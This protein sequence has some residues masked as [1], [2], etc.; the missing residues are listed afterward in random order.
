M[1]SWHCVWLLCTHEEGLLACAPGSRE[2]SDH[3]SPLSWE[4]SRYFILSP[5]VISCLQARMR[6][7]VCFQSDLP[8]SPEKVFLNGV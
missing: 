1:F 7:E 5:T 6:R 3:V 4:I 8:L 2:V